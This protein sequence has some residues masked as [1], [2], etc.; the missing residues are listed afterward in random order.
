MDP[1]RSG[2]SLRN[3]SQLSGQEFLMSGMDL[4]GLDGAFQVWKG[5]SGAC[6]SHSLVC[7]GSLRPEFGP[8]NHGN[9]SCRAG[10]V[11]LCQSW[12]LSDL[13]REWTVWPEI[14][15]FRPDIAPFSFTGNN[16]RD[17]RERTIS[18][19]IRLRYNAISRA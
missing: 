2:I 12:A 11:H 15:S 3:F 14:G 5:P 18:Y 17:R 9:G 4:S 6:D 1:L 8:V 16:C 13:S 19:Y 7:N 10:M